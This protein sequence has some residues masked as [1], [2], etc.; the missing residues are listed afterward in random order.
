MALYAITRN[1]EIGVDVE[2]VRS[3]FEYE[4]LAKRFFFNQRGGHFAYDT[5]RK[6][7]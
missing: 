7:A 3:D 6:E 5:D 4:E 2:R 1:L